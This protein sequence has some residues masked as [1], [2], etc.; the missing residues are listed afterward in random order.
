MHSAFQLPL[1]VM[2]KLLLLV[3][4]L[5]LPAGSLLAQR[6]LPREEY[7]TRIE[8]CEAILREFMAKPD[9]AIPQEIL[10]NARGLVITNQFKAGFILGIKDGYG[11]VMVKRPDGSWSLPALVNA[12]EASIGLQLGG[13]AVET[14]FV[15]MDSETP[16][17]LFNDRFNVGVDAKAVAG[18]RAAEATNVN[19]EFLTTPVLVYTKSTGL[20]AGATVKAG[21]IQRNDAGNRTFYQTT[22]ALP[23]LLYSDWVTPQPEVRPLID[24]V[25]RLSP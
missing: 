15:L 10:R 24:Y 11:V 21:W 8:S 5:S 2:K 1:A 20:F 18:P 14:V 3:L 9:T 6:A 22:Y 23:E 12:G 25:S 4:A 19:R 17:L 7:V 16:K 13:T